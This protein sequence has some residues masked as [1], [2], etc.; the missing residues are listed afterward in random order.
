MEFPLPEGEGQG[1]GEPRL[2]T[3]PVYLPRTSTEPSELE[4]AYLCA[5]RV[6]VANHQR[7]SLVNT[8]LTH[9]TFRGKYSSACAHKEQTK[10]L[11]VRQAS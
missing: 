5:L 11:T 2:I 9:F 4:Y 8:V 7:F 6:S 10:E 3:T 1:E